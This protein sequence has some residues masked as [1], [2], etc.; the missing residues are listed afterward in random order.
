MNQMLNSEQLLT[1]IRDQIDH[2]ATARELV[3]RLKIPREQRSTS[4]AC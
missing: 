2:P 3:Q 4:S 1:A